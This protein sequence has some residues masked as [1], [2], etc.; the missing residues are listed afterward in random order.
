MGGLFDDIIVIPNK[1]RA[2]TGIQIIHQDD[3]GP[4]VLGIEFLWVT[5]QVPIYQ[6]QTEVHE[7]AFIVFIKKKL[8]IWHLYV[9][10]LLFW[11]AIYLGTV[12]LS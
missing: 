6:H 7:I 10:Q 3:F 5:C 1:D 4:I 12:P 11:Y 2:L 8:C 9:W